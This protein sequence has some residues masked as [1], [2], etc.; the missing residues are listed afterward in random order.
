MPLRNKVDIIEGQIEYWQHRLPKKSLSKDLEEIPSSI[1]LQAEFQELKQ[2]NDD[3]MWQL[4]HAIGDL[5]ARMTVLQSRFSTDSWEVVSDRV[6]SE[7][8]RM[9]ATLNER[10]AEVERAML[11]RSHSSPATASDQTRIAQEELQGLDFS[12]D[13]SLRAFSREAEELRVLMLSQSRTSPLKLLER[14]RSDSRQKDSPRLVEGSTSARQTRA[15]SS[16]A[17]SSSAVLA[18]TPTRV[19]ES[20]PSN[21][22]QFSC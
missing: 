3:R 7:A 20:G 18:P 21:T 17:A 9:S 1:E 4:R 16:A 11:T 14:E 6:A 10:V 13:A 5:D 12:V 22:S 15:T 8:S 2:N 19:Q